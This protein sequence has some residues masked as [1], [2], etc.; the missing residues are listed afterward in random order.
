MKNTDGTSKEKPGDCKISI[1]IWVLLAILIGFI[2]L[3]MLMPTSG[4][5][6]EKVRKISCASNLKQIGLALEMYSNDYMQKLPDKPGA[7]GL[8]QLRSLDYIVDYKV[9][10]CPSTS[11]IPGKDGKPLTEAN[12]SYCFRGGMSKADSA[13]SA[14]CWDKTDNHKNFGN[15]LFLDGHVNGVSGA[16]WMREIR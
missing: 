16:N 4:R 15:I 3:G 12:V 6:S 8:E 1:I 11:A 5:V 13:N 9:F 7:A 14:I 2:L 10:V